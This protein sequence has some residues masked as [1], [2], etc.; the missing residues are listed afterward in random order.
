MASPHLQVDDLLKAYLVGT[1]LDLKKTHAQRALICG[2]YDTYPAGLHDFVQN[3]FALNEDLE[4]TPL[5]GVR[6]LRILAD[7]PVTEH[8]GALIDVETLEAYCQG[9]NLE[10]RA[11]RLWLDVMLKSGL[12]LNFDPTVQD[13]DGAA[14]L[15]I[16]PAGR[17]HLHLASAEFEYLG[18]ML[19]A[20]PLLDEATFHNL[21]Y[22]LKRKQWRTAVATFVDYLV[23]E[24]RSYCSLP[25]HPAYDSQ[26]RIVPALESVA[27]RLRRPRT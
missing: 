24:D 16:A 12:C 6:I 8:E 2:H 3:L 20:T 23:K 11:V 18:A 19:Q 25:D 14:R 26:R 21:Q 10:V 7:V 17:Q 5:M 13:I 22:A 27:E 9:M 4:T 15:E 1:G